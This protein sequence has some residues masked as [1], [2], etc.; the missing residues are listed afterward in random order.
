M[1]NFI[2]LTESAHNKAK[3]F[4]ST[5]ASDYFIR[6]SV[7]GGGCSGLTHDLL[8]D[9]ILTEK[10]IINEIDEVKVV[11]D[12]KSIIYLMDTILDYSDGLNGKGFS[13]SN[14]NWQREC[15]CGESFSM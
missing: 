7:K 8:Y 11:T 15:G 9:N 10:D 2:T 4:L 13:F 3:Y 12:R 5:Y 14:K 1:E 6:I